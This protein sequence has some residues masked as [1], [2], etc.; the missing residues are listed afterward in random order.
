[1]SESSNIVFCMG[2]CDLMMSQWYLP[3]TC[4]PANTD[5][6]L[7]SWGKQKPILIS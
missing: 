2:W 1:M 4:Q 3:G 6:E 5:T 7:K